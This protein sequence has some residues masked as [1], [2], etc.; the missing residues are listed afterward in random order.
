MRR[1]WAVTW[2]AAA[3]VLGV[4][5]GI[6]LTYG[7][8]VVPRS[9]ELRRLRP[10][11]SA[12]RQLDLPGVIKAGHVT[13]SWVIQEDNLDASGYGA[14]Q[15][16]GRVVRGRATVPVESQEAAL[17]VIAQQLQAQLTVGGYISRLDSESDRTGDGLYWRQ[18]IG[19]EGP[20]RG[21]AAVVIGLG[22]GERLVVLIMIDER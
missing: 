4:L 1:F 20:N 8:V 13:P 6:A 5:L 19:F 7:T 18:T 2:L 14:G 17:A 11:T 22:E 9:S 16:H 12:V 21:G 3:G 10:L 15:M